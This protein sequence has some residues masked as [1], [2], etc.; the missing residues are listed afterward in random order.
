MAHAPWP[1]YERGSC[2][3]N[4]RERA[5][6][7]CAIGGQD[8][9]QLLERLHPEVRWQSFFAALSL[10]GE[11]TG[12]DGMRQYMTDLY[13]AFEYLRPEIGDMLDA[14]NV[15]VGLGRIYYRAGEAA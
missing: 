5:A 12:H 10:R 6:H 2:R 1:A 15:V 9:D 7:N 13:E 11:Y 4:R 14:G 3:V 8:L